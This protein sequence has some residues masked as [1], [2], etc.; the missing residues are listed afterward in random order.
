ME[1]LS[2]HSIK[3]SDNDPDDKL[4]RFY[5]QTCIFITGGTGFL[6]KLLLLKLLN[7]SELHVQKIYLMMRSKNNYSVEQRLAK[8]LKEQVRQI[9]YNSIIIYLLIFL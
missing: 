3:W 4:L 2:S 8:I 1:K 6:G 9:E 5:Q 7:T